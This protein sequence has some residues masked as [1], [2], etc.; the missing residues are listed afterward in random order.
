M[1]IPQ[2]DSCR[3]I[4]IEQIHQRI[5]A[6][7]FQYKSVRVAGRI[8]DLINDKGLTVIRQPEWQFWVAEEHPQFQVNTFFV[9]DK[10]L[11]VGK[12]YEFLGEI[13]VAEGGLVILKARVIKPLDNFHAKVYTETASDM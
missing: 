13:E 6:D 9:R 10:N 12:Y 5:A 4:S 8:A 1:I 2:L 7:N 3:F 11:E